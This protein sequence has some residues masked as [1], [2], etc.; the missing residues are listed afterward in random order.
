MSRN[1]I[2]KHKIICIGCPKGCRI[3]LES[4][5]GKIKTISD[6]SCP[7]GVQHA[8]KEFA[9]P[10]RILPTTVRVING[11]LP[12]VPVKTAAPI[13]KDLLL[14]SMVEIART[15]VRAPVKIGQ[16]IKKD[17]MKSGV[18][19]IATATVEEKNNTTRRR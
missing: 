8:R 17:L 4:S 14:P 10:T 16:L 7:I 15:E 11:E 9:D 1:I 6:Y 3:T 19:L 18:D 2:N 12:L 13:A 5:N